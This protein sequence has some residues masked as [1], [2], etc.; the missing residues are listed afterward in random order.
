MA[1]LGYN[2][3]RATAHTKL[4]NMTSNLAALFFFAINGYVVWQI[5]LL[6]GIAQMLGATAGA[7]L[8]IRR[9]AALVRPLIVTVCLAVTIKLLW[10]QQG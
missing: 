10:S 9:G 8:V 2:M 7:H 4:L 1:L 3:T 6:M 5:G